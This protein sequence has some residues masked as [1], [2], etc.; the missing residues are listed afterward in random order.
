MKNFKKKKYKITLKLIRANHIT[1]SYVKWMN[2][3][4]VVK[5]TEQ[6]NKKHTI[7]DIKKFVKEKINSPVD[8]LYGIFIF[9]K[10]K[11]HIGNLKIGPVNKIHQTAEISYFIGDKKYW[12]IGIGSQA[13][14]KATEICKKKYKL[15]K[16]IA[17]CYSVNKGS[18][19]VL[20]KNKFK[21]EA[22]L[23]SHIFFENKRINKIIYGLV[24]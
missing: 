1:K 11:I 2:D 8:F 22:L 14:K 10:K 3:Y 18:I 4:E 20:E 23:K 7:A 19:R 5:Y 9:D 13:V 6:K 12:K 17:G 24:L 16:L 15:K 21:K